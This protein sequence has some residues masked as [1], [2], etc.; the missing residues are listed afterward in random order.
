MHLKS[1]DDA[2]KEPQKK[3]VDNKGKNSQGQDIERQSENDEERLDGDVDQPPQERQNKR[4]SKTFYRNPRHDIGQGQKTE[5][6]HHP[7]NNY[8]TRVINDT[9]LL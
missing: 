6:T 4:R 9:T 7:S 5:S 2:P 1:F 3:T 8:H